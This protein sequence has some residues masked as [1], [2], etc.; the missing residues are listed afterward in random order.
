MSS[1]ATLTAICFRHPDSNGDIF[2]TRSF[3]A[4][5]RW[6]IC[7]AIRAPDRGRTTTPVLCS[8]CRCPTRQSASQCSS[9]SVRSIIPRRDP[10][11]SS[12]G[13]YEFP[14]ALDLTFPFNAFDSDGDG[15]TATLPFAST[16]QARP[17]LRL[18]FVTIDYSALPGGV[19]INLADSAQHRL[20]PTVAAPTPR[21]ISKA[22]AGGHR[23]R[24]RRTGVAHAIGTDSR[25]R[26]YRRRRRQ[27]L[28][29]SAA[30]DLIRGGDGGDDL[31]RRRRTTRIYGGGGATAILGD[32]A[33]TGSTAARRGSIPGRSGRR[34]DLWRRRQR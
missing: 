3:P 21:P 31:W 14:H 13:A 33:P 25:R 16:R 5:G 32:G 9:C 6:S 10:A 30:T 22:S 23:P 4:C 24:Q 29:G 19:F 17:I 8:G 12:P 1:C 28:E 18:Q 7:S 20:A 26:H 34:L 15:V 11:R 27:R 2:F